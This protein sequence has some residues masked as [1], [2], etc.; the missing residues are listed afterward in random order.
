MGTAA[1]G[2]AFGGIS[3]L[4]EAMH[5]LEDPVPPEFVRE[6]Q[7][8]TIIE[9]VPEEFFETV[10]SESLKLPARVWRDYFEGVVLADATPL[11]EIEATTL[12][13]WGEHD[14]YPPRE[15]Q[16]RLAREIPDSTLKVYPESSH[17]MHWER[18]EEVVWDLEGF[19]KDYKS[20]PVILSYRSTSKSCSQTS[21]Q[22][23]T[24]RGN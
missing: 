22:T 24:H 8:S 9:P 7:Q 6:F 11:R 23:P 14:L 13:L 16:E 21:P 2:S 10:I 19:M 12:I 17:V 15:E 18:P 5:T 20:R 1:E 3:E 4:G